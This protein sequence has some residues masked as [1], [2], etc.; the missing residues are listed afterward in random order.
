MRKLI[1]AILNSI[2]QPLKLCCLRRKEYDRLQSERRIFLSLAKGNKATNNYSSLVNCIIFSKN[3]ACQLQ[4][5]LRSFEDQVRD[6][7]HTKILYEASSEL[8]NEAYDEVQSDFTASNIEWIPQRD[9]RKDLLRILQGIEAKWLFFLV[10][11]MVFI[12]PVDFSVFENVSP[13]STVAS[14]RLAPHIR[15]SYTMNTS[16]QVPQFETY[17][18]DNNLL[19]WPWEHG[20]SDWGYPLS[21]DGHLFAPE[22][23]RSIAEKSNFR[24]PN[25]FE[26]AL[27][28]AK[29]V[30]LKRYGLCYPE[31]RVVNLPLNKVQQENSN[32]CGDI[33]EKS[34]LNKWKQG[35]Q[36]DV[37]S[38]YGT[39]N[40]SVHQE[41]RVQFEN[42]DH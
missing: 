42:R 12:R 4:A 1:A 26:S 30:F 2:L 40:E 6:S 22:E 8:H 41:L 35:C 33:S 37:K 11:D 13:K 39:V 28:L 14:L 16:M 34:L 23:I 31:S 29:P 24:A 15:F 10:D 3:R 21:V 32:L 19:Q 5:L 27:Q 36:I 9:F 25:S 17:S 20:E 38:L 18:H 7:V